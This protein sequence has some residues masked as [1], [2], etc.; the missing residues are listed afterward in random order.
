MAAHLLHQ[1]PRRDT[2]PPFPAQCRPLYRCF[3]G[4]IEGSCRGVAADHPLLASRTRAK[5]AWG[6]Q[7]S[8][9]TSWA[10]AGREVIIKG[11][12]MFI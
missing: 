10:Q 11:P 4:T 5:P 6:Q 2:D 3:Q 7:P 8:G 12:Y 9:S 1:C